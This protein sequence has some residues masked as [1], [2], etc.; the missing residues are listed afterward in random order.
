MKPWLESIRGEAPRV[1]RVRH[2][3]VAREVRVAEVRPLGPHLLRVTFAGPSLAGFVSLSFDDHVKFIFRNAQGD[4]VK[5]DY[6][7]RACDPVAATLA[8][9]FALHEHGPASDWAR[10]AQIGQVV[11]V[12][13][14]RGSRILP[15]DLDWHLLIGDLSA[16]PAIARRLE[17]LPAHSRAIVRLRVPD[18]AA[19]I[20]L[21]SQAD[22]DLQW[23]TS[24]EDL[25]ASLRAL[26]PL[27]GEGY[28][29]A[30]GETGLMKR[31]RDLLAGECGIPRHAMRVAAYWRHGV[32]DFHETIAE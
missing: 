5:R 30:A 20:D 17:E 11:T 14:P 18:E 3:V 26:P 6:T 15:P 27:A 21:A 7:P 2:E 13:G 10:Q 31:V 32:A 24:D 25:L 16:L 19:R 29:W 4:T 23:L 1:Q 8:L 12:A 9:E 28:A 22:A